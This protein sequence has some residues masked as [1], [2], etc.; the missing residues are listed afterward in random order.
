[1]AQIN[2]AGGSLPGRTRAQLS[3]SATV[4]PRF[5][6]PPAE[7]PW[8]VTLYQRLV[9]IARSAGQLARAG[10]ADLQPRLATFEGLLAR[11]ARP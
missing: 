9:A 1:V 2:A 8:T 3:L 5:A 6:N 10:P 7:L 11:L 4:A